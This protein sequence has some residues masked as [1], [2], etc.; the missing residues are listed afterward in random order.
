MTDTT[1]PLTPPTRGG[2]G[3]QPEKIDPQDRAQ[4]AESPVSLRRVAG[5]FRPH[6]RTVAVVTALIVAISVIS[7]AQPFLL[8]A[9]IDDAL[10]HQDVRLL[11]WAVGGMLAVTVVSQLLGVV[12]TWLTT[13]VGQRVMHGLRTDVFRH[14]QRQSVAFF[15]R[16]RSG[17]VQSRLT[18]DISG[19]QSVITSTATSIASNLTTAVATAIAM[20]A[21]SPRLSLLSLL[22]I[23]PAVLMTRKVA[24][25][26]RDITAQR[27]RRLADLH[28]Q[29]EEG[30]T[31]SGATLVKTLG[32]G[33]ATADRFAA[34]STD[35]IDLELRSQLAGRWRMA[36]MQ[37]IFAAIPALIYLAAGLP[38]TSGG[39]TIGTLIAF[40]TL[41]SG[42]F[43]PLMG[44]LDVGAQWVT[45]MALFSRIFGYLDLP[46]EVA[47]P[48]DPVAV[49]H[50]RLRGEVRFE[51]VAFSHDPSAAEHTYAVDDVTLHVPAGT[52]LALVGET[53]SGKSSLAGLLARL[54]DPQSGRV[55]IDGVDLRDLDPADLARIVGVVSQDTYLVHA[56]I[57]DNLLLAAPGATD[58]E[59]WQALAAAQV[60]P[61]VA[62][63]PDG[64][65]TVVGA[66]GHRFSGGEKQRLAIAR[67]LLRNPRVLVLDEATSAL[68]NE[69][70]RELQAAIDRLMA[71]RTT[72]T[73]AHR[74]ST[75]RDAEQIA[76][77]DRGRVAELGDH[78]ELMARG[79]RY[80]RLVEAREGSAREALAA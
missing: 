77:L 55:T 63:L 64:L 8:R 65:D 51:G 52:T 15:T 54:H 31:V 53:G 9:V 27:Q 49:Q 60:A 30:L 29:V 76:V 59:L 58:D 3:R 40:T 41:Q 6:V 50:D 23:P 69:T 7:M 56:S 12:Q 79:G 62:S 34:T 39:M 19:M 71:G 16:T 46:V 32:A 72:L 36:T 44:L 10:P 80:A 42:I 70:E 74:L 25:L 66:R 1:S 45:S 28:S 37:I 26:R 78:D 22:V 57:R 38:A 48:A 73:I 33:E 67:T 47:P 18:H 68:D 17:E 24:L 75:I 5:L 13:A 20:V 2:R 11:L 61:L 43:R 14:L 21:L 4:L 35:L